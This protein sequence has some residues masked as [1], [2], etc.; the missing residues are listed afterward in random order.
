[1][2]G[3]NSVSRLERKLQA[4]RTLTFEFIRDLRDQDPHQHAHAAHLLYVNFQ[5]HCQFALIALQLEQRYEKRDQ[6]T[7]KYDLRKYDWN[8]KNETSRNRP[9]KYRDTSTEEQK[10][11]VQTEFLNLCPGLPDEQ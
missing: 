3:Q 11:T 8:K 6:A 2:N 1:M 7:P 9:K 4:I 10:K 5:E